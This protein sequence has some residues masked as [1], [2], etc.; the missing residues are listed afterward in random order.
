MDL[1]IASYNM[2]GFRN[3]GLM[4]HSLCDDSYDIIMVQEHWLLPPNVSLL[5]DSNSNYSGFAISG[6]CN[7][8]EYVL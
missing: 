1:K 7:V 4:L 2:H 6:I 3:G 5:T 8:N